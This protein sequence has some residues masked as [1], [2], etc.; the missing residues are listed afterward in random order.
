MPDQ[1]LGDAAVLERTV[2][3]KE[4][5]EGDAEA[6]YV[7]TDI[8][9]VAIDGLF[10]GEVVGGAEDGVAVVFLSYRLFFVVEKAREAE[11]EDFDDAG[12]IHDQV[13]RLDVAVDE[14]R[15]VGVLEAERGL[16][17]VVGGPLRVQR[18]AP[19]DEFLQADAV[20]VLHNEEVEFSVAVDIVGANDIG[21]AQL[22]DRLGFALEPFDLA[23]VVS[24]HGRQ[25]LDGHR[26]AHDAM[27]TKIDG[28]HAA[29]AK[30]FEDDVFA[31]KDEVPPA[32]AH[33]SDR[34]G[35]V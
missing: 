24:L 22:R 29:G 16:V 8:D 4:K 5:I 1:F 27:G 14:A 17:H 11:V 23:G 20:D 35:T 6:V 10:G 15:L 12:A 31:A 30:R 25:H 19:I 21:V 34:P 18:A 32:T 9:I 13:G 28:A 3:G 7:T 2:A 26:A 33:A